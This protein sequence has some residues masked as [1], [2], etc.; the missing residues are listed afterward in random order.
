MDKICDDIKEKREGYLKKPGR[1]SGS[2]HNWTN[3]HKIE[4]PECYSFLFSPIAEDGPEIIL[5][6]DIAR[7]IDYLK[8]WKEGD[9][10]FM[11]YLPITMPHPPY[12]TLERFQSMYNPELL[13]D[14]LIQP[15]ETEGKPSYM[16]LIRKYRRLDQLSPEYM[17]KIHATYLGM[18]SYVDYLLGEIMNTM[19]EQGLTEN[20][21]LIVS[22][23]HGDWSGNYGLVEKWP[24]AMDDLLLRV[25]L[26]FRMPGNKAGHVVHE[27]VELF[28]IMATVMELAGIKAEHTH[29][30]RSLAPQLKGVAGDPGRLVFAEGGYDLQD[31]VCFENKC[32]LN[33]DSVYYPKLKQQAEYPQSVCR[34]VMVRGIEHKLVIRTSGENELYDLEKDP[35]ERINVYADHNY[36]DIRSKLEGA[37]LDS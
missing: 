28:D 7:G 6:E 20:T 16:N 2:V 21:T 1:R 17:A 10:P 31:E 19:E 27:Q 11:L 35:K 8:A 36:A 22:S 9:K 33:E 15:G 18:N 30:A 4:D 14:Q 37:L 23:D 12:A 13:A 3:P 5:E 32:I 34:T 25:P 24:N 29:F 26:L